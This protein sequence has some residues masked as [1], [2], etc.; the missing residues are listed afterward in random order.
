MPT[1]A[2]WS[3]AARKTNARRIVVINNARCGSANVLPCDLHLRW[4]AERQPSRGNASS[5]VGLLLA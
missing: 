3:A 2:D 1:I 5:K 4:A